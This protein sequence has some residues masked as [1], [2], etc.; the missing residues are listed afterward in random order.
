MAHGAPAAPWG[1]WSATLIR[2]Q[3]RIRWSQFFDQ[4]G[5]TPVMRA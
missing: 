3:L 5:T 2:P 4:G 1:R